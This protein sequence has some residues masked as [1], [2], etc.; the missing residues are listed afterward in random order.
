M[1]QTASVRRTLADIIN[2]KITEKATEIRTQLSGFNTVL[3]S[4]F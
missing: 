3:W 1:S 4:Y 2:E